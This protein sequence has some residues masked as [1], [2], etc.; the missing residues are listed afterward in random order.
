[1]RSLVYTAAINKSFWKIV[2]F[3]LIVEIDYFVRDLRKRL[4][5]VSFKVKKGNF[6]FK[7]KYFREMNFIEIDSAWWYINE[8]FRSSFYEGTCI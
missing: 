4:I 7:K 2:I 3:V 6:Q 8:S 5:L 1:M